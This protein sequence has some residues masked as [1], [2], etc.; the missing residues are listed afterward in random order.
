[1]VI[2]RD[3][4]FE[5]WPAEADPIALAICPL[6]TFVIEATAPESPERARAMSEVLA[7]V[8]R[9]KRALMPAPKLN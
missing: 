7:A 9:L 6:L 3:E 2:E 5:P 1:M 4:E 8:E